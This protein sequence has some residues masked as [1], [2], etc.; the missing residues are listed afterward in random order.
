MKHLASRITAVRAIAL[1]AVLA[2]G[3]A[4]VLASGGS[5]VAATAVSAPTITVT[6]YPEEIGVGD[7]SGITYTITDPNSSGSLYNIG[8]TDTLPSFVSID[9]PTG[10]TDSGCGSN[11]TFGAGSGNGA[12]GASGITVKAGTPCT[13]SLSVVGNS[14]GNATD[15][16]SGFTYSTSATGAA[17]TAPATSESTASLD[18]I[19]LPTAT[20]TRPAANATYAY[21]QKVKA[22]YSCSAP[23]YAYGSSLA[24][25]LGTDDLYNT[26]NPGQDLDT[27]V[28]GKHYLQVQA[29]NTL[30]DTVDAQVN[31]TVLPDNLVPLAAAK[32]GAGGALKLTLKVP[33]AGTL[34]LV[35]RHGATTV[36]SRTVKLSAAHKSL[37]AELG[38][39]RAGRKLF[40]ADRHT[41]KV[42]LE[43]SFVPKGGKAHSYTKVE[44]LG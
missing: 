6:F 24:D 38:L 11:A 30:G 14:P 39:N 37:L 19:A 12:D 20:I 34:K 44:K 7:S 16:L 2:C 13:I 10:L 22:A 25:C 18:V 35:E 26:I 41:L 1:A 15:T 21:G 31:Y 27:T 36:A 42:T 8:F 3:G 32:P 29:I 9:N 43:V 23:T 33:G 17:L 4:A 5:A 40:N 28:P